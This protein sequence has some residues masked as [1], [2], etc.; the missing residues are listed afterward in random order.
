MVQS[1]QPRVQ[2]G[3]GKWHATARVLDAHLTV[4]FL[5]F[6]LL[7]LLLLLSLQL[8]LVVVVVIMQLLVQPPKPLQQ[9][10]THLMH[11]RRRQPNAYR[12]RSFATNLFVK[13][14]RATPAPNATS[15]HVNT[16]A[17]KYIYIYIYW[18]YMDQRVPRK[19][20]P[21][22]SSAE[23]GLILAGNYLP[24]RGLKL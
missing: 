13:L 21:Q 15:V 24:V 7:Y 20:F 16:F 14:F 8:L 19:C 3:S 18:K 4:L 9:P 10:A 12:R 6:L 17:L 11:R 22:I 2:K 5:Q 23:F 1:H